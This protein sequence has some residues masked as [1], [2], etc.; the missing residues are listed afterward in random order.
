MQTFVEKQQKQLIKKFHTLLGR[1]GI[2]ND[3]KLTILS[4]YGVTTSK[5]LSCGDL[6]DVCDKIYSML[7]K[8]VSDIDTLRKRVM[9]AIFRNLELTRPGEKFTYEYVKNIACRAAKRND[10]NK[11]DINTLRGIYNAFCRQNKA[12]ENT[13]REDNYTGTMLNTTTQAMA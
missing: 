1:A 5:D 7:N 9:R 6:I 12:F 2:D 10:F 13:M 4:S 8:H 11:I 3:S